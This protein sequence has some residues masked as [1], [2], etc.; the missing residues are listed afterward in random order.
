MSVVKACEKYNYLFRA[1]TQEISTVSTSEVTLRT[2]TVPGDSMGIN[3][4]IRAVALW[5]SAGGNFSK[6]M[7]VKFAGNT[8][9]QQIH[10]S[11]N[12][13]YD[14]VPA[15]IWNQ[16]ATNAQDSSLLGAQLHNTNNVVGSWAVD[17]TLDFDITFT[18]LV[19]N[20][21]NTL[22]LRFASVEVWRFDD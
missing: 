4:Y 20:A 13:Q 8:V 15:F 19:A 12:Q 7:R 21:G 5:R 6:T 9:K 22:Y 3:G 10:T 2:I 17:T 14:N 18:G 1:E 11:G 16:G